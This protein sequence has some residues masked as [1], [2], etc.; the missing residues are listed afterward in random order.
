M[1]MEYFKIWAMWLENMGPWNRCFREYTIWLL[2]DDFK[3]VTLTT[4]QLSLSK[5]TNKV[6]QIPGNLKQS[7]LKILPKRGTKLLW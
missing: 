6:S 5:E 1:L 4:F 3:L 2:E 7:H